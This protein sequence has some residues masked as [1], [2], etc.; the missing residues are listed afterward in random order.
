M[1]GMRSPLC[2]GTILSLHS[3]NQVIHQFVVIIVRQPQRQTIIRTVLRTR[4]VIG[5]AYHDY[6]R[7]T[8]AGYGSEDFFIYAMSGTEDFAYAAFTNQIQAMINAPGGIF[9]DAAHG[10]SGKSTVA[11]AF[12]QFLPR[13]PLCVGTILSLHSRNQVGA[14]GKCA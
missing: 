10:K 9:V 3:R 11:A 7:H 6:R 14:G 1:M 12:R 4:I 8:E 5:R 2:V 13:S